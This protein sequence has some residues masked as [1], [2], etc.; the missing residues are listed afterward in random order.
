MFR[1]LSWLH[2]A[3]ARRLHGAA[4]MPNASFSVA[5][6][7]GGPAGLTAA[8][9]LQ[10]A[11]ARVSLF[12]A[13]PHLGG[14]TRTDE[15]EGARIDTG[16]QLFGSSYTR[17]IA[18]LDDLGIR[19]RLVRSPG[20]DALW[21]DGRVHEVVYGSVPSM[22][23]SG[24][25]PMRTKLRL[26]A[27]YVPFLARHASALT[28]HA[29]ERTAA[30]GL[31]G[32]SIAQWGVREMGDD[33]V[34]F[35]VHPHLTT[36]YGA[37][38][39]DTSAALY[40]VLARQGVDVSVFALRGGA[41]TLCD[42]LGDALRGAGAELL[43]G[44][45][46]QAV[47]P[48]GAGVTISM[49]GG[50]HDFDAAVVAVPAPAARALLPAGPAPLADWLDGVRFRPA[51]TAALLLDRPLDA[52]FFGLSFPRGAMRTL[53][54]VCVEANKIPG[55]VPE[56]RGLL[57]VFLHPAAAAATID[58]D[59]RAVVDALLPELGRVLPAVTETITRARV[60]R[61]AHGQPVVGPGYF[62]HLARYRELAAAPSRVALA[63]EYLYLPSV[64]GAVT[65]GDAAAASLLRHL[66]SRDHRRS[67]PTTDS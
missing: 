8:F 3:P 11:G 12:E 45:A 32:E 2:Y 31:D 63:G 24:A 1:D 66:A 27:T 16:A 10:R 50:E 53:A 4:R 34:D 23:A 18:L 13:A 29:P 17:L 61:W 25:L 64:E 43:L 56:G 21:R 65:S 22:L 20:R 48:S 42:A 60:Y 41:G 38:P 62:G 36:L 35:L 26:G 55:L 54:A 19:D 30:A 33:F 28:L 52:R 6:V 15:I 57:V 44:R 14:R 67:E 46:V 47:T 40:H 59:S 37:P 7:G 49:P 51:M 5:V 39:A 58:A 9:R